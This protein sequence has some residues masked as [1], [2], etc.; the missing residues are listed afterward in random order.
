[1]VLVTIKRD[2]Q[3]TVIVSGA[4]YR[5]K[6]IVIYEDGYKM[7][8]NE[9]LPKVLLYDVKKV[10]LDWDGDG[11]VLHLRLGCDCE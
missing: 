9:N 8:D 10:R 11:L 5:A 6:N 4:V 1:M 2:T 3:I 7:F